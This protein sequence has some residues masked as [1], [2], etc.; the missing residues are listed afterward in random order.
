MKAE[1]L[2]ENIE[3][4][5]P[6]LGKVLPA[7]SQIPVLSNILV[8]ATDEGIFLYA[9]DLELGVRIKVPAKIEEKGSTTIPGKQ[10]IETLTSL[11]KGK[12]EISLE[13][14]HL[15]LKSQGN[16][17]LFNTIAREEFP[18][19]FE[20]KGKKIGIFSQDDLRKIFLKLIFSVSL[21]EARPELTGILMSQKKTGIDFVATDGF[22]LSLKRQNEKTILEEGE[23]L[24][25]SSKL[26]QEAMSLKDEG[27]TVFYV[28][29]KGNQVLF[30]TANTILV[31]RLI[32]GDFPNYEKVIPSH[33][34]TRVVADTDDFLQKIRLASIFARDSAN[35][36]RLKIEEGKI[37]IFAKSSGL[38][39]GEASLEVE[40]DGDDNEIAFNVKFLLDFLK[41]ADSK[42]VVMELNSPLEPSLFKL[43]GVKDFLHIIMPVRVQE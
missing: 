23:G 17:I 28:Q 34:K 36:V 2:V 33:N 6:L 40:Q 14:E 32:S 9:T 24:I 30:E 12:I 18:G 22:R 38:G 43:D 29:E 37:K 19:L 21:D 8:E 5:L 11:P 13:K 1:F 10:F 31:G 41:N 20:E 15:I 25:L 35:I 26:I 16:K 39:E 27:D 4:F 3:K 42:R 7:H